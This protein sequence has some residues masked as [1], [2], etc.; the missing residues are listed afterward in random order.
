GIALRQVRLKPQPEVHGQV[1]THAPGVLYI[2][3]VVVGLVVVIERPA[4]AES[5]ELAGDKIG[6]T[7]SADAARGRVLAREVE[8]AIHAARVLCVHVS[9]DILRAQLSLVLAL[10]DRKILGTRIV[11]G[12]EVPGVAGAACERKAVG[13]AE[14]HLRRD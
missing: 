14:I 8:I 10:D 11:Q 12:I 5:V 2:E 4:L 9:A 7:E 3:P 1:R 6:I 13:Y